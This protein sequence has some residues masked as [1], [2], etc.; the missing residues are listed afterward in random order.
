MPKCTIH[1]AVI[2]SAVCF[3]F[4]DFRPDFFRTGEDA[5]SSI[6]QIEYD[7]L[8]YATNAGNSFGFES[9]NDLACRRFQ[10]FWLGSQP[11][12][13]DHVTS[14]PA[15]QAARN[16]FDF[17]KFWHEISLQARAQAA[18][19]RLQGTAHLRSKI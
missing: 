9:R 3:V 16:G 7:V 8:P 11:N 5:P 17:G 15:S 2:G 4:E 18:G 6:L 19:F 10:R 13:F 12:G 14:N 1:C